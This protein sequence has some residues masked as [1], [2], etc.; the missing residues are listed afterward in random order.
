MWPIQLPYGLSSFHRLMQAN[1]EIPAVKDGVIPRFQLLTLDQIAAIPPIPASTASA[2]SKTTPSLPLASCLPIYLPTGTETQQQRY[3]V[4]M[5]VSNS[6]SQ[7]SK[8]STAT[9]QNKR[10]RASRS[11]KRRISAAQDKIDASRKKKDKKH[12]K[13][14]HEERSKNKLV[15][16]KPLRPNKRLGAHRDVP[17]TIDGGDNSEGDPALERVTAAFRYEYI[18]SALGVCGIC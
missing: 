17:I 15:P 14:R 1:R 7:A 11:Q 8:S 18:C 10:K 12:S 13:T 9:A 6:T 4:D 2:T 16:Q 5:G 3:T